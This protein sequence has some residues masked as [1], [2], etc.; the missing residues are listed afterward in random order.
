MSYHI[1][2]FVIPFPGALEEKRWGVAVS[3]WL[4]GVLM[5]LYQLK[6]FALVAWSSC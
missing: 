1:N 6:F 4:C 2:M 3:V 5:D